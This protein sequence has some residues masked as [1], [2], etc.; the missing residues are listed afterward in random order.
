M[1]THRLGCGYN[2]NGSQSW[3]IPSMSIMHVSSFSHYAGTIRFISIPGSQHVQ[4]IYFD[5]NVIK[6]VGACGSRVRDFTNTELRLCTG[7][8]TKGILR[9]TG[10]P[11]YNQWHFYTDELG[12]LP[13]GLMSCNE[14]MA[15]LYPGLSW[16]SSLARAMVNWETPCWKGTE[17][18]QK[19]LNFL[20]FDDTVSLQNKRVWSQV[21]W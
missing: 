16:V 3:V 1:Q 17:V 6:G 20:P 18:L 21:D 7:I 10:D 19:I 5:S 8:T 11:R 15:E 2:N 14:P 9:L 12:T 13:D 4:S